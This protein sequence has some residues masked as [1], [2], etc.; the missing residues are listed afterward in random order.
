MHRRDETNG[1][2]KRQV[3]GPED[4]LPGCARGLTTMRGN[5]VHPRRRQQRKANRSMRPQGDA[6]TLHN[7]RAARAQQC[8]NSPAEMDIGS[9]A[10]G[11][12]HLVRALGKRPD[13]AD[14]NS[15]RQL[16]SRRKEILTP[17]AAEVSHLWEP[18]A[19]AAQHFSA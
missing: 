8:S 19:L 16:R 3:N 2:S 14:D 15:R 12:N 6:V 11:E 5:L 17:A 1:W 4:S 13:G 10:A 9:P 7:I 18:Q